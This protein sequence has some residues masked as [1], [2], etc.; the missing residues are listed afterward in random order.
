MSKPLSPIIEKVKAFEKELEAL[1]HDELR[2]KTEAFKNKIAEA[3]KAY[4]DK[5]NE[6]LQ[7]A[8]TTEDIDKREDI[9]NEIDKLKDRVIQ[10][11]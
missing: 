11:Y 9:Y 7:E 5:I 1:S 8:E 3:R 4:D 6:L 2:A 10:S